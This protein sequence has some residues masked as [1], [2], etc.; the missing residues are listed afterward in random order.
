MGNY[1]FSFLKYSQFT[2]LYPFPLYS[3]MTQPYTHI[4]TH[5]HIH[6]FCYIPSSVP[7]PIS[8]RGRA[9]ALDTLP[10]VFMTVRAADLLC[11]RQ[12]QERVHSVTT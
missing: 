6:T 1:F 11:V 7:E 10:H 2:M 12:C 4:H 3:N 8:I 9:R 5:T